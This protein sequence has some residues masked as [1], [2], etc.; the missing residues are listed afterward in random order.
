[1]PSAWMCNVQVFA[2]LPDHCYVEPE[3]PW[4]V[5]GKW[6]RREQEAFQLPVSQRESSG[7]SAD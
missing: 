3:Q 2:A 1:M 6:E 7:C 5:V 4:P